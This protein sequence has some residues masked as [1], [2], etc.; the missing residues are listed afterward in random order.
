M[1]T[2][3]TITQFFEN[4]LM[5]PPTVAELAVREA[6]I[7]NGS[8]T[9]E[10]ICLAIVNSQESQTYVHQMFRV[11]QTAFDRLPDFN[12]LDGWVDDLRD[13]SATSMDMINGFLNS[14]EWG[15]TYGSTDVLPATIQSFYQNMLGRAAS[16]QEVSDWLSSGDSLGEIL[17]GVANSAEAINLSNG[18]IISVLQRACETEDP[19]TLYTGL[20]SLFD[21]LPDPVDPTGP[22]TG[23]PGGPGDPVNGPPSVELDN[24]VT[25]LAENSDTSSRI[26]VADIVV[27]DDGLGV[28][29]LALSGDDAGLFEIDGDELFLRANTA[30]DFEGANT[31]LDVTVEVDDTTVGGTPDDTVDLTIQVTDVNEA[32]DI[33]GAETITV[34]HQENDAG[35]VVDVQS[36]DPDLG[37]SEGAGLTYELSQLNGGGG[38]NGWFTID[39]DTGELT[40]K[41]P[42]NF[43][44]PQDG[45]DAGDG[46]G[47]EV[48]EGGGPGGNEGGGPG[49]GE[50]DG[51]NNGR[52]FFRRNVEQI[53]ANPAGDNS[54]QVQVSVTDGE[55]TDTQ[56]INVEVTD[57][58]ERPEI[59][60]GDAVTINFPETL[61]PQ[62]GVPIFVRNVETDDDDDG[63]GDGLTY[64]L[65]NNSG[66]AI[67]NHLFTINMDNGEI[68]FLE[69]PDFEDPKDGTGPMPMPMM[70]RNEGRDPGEMPGGGGNDPVGDNAYEIEVSVTDGEFSDTQRLTINVTNLPDGENLAPV[71]NGGD[72][73]QVAVNEGSNLDYD[74]DSTDDNDSEGN[75]LTYS[76]STNNNR[77]NDNNLFQLSANGVLNF[78]VNPNVDAETQYF[79]QV[80]VTDSGGLTDFQ[81]IIV[82]VT[83]GGQ[84]GRPNLLAAAGAAD[85]DVADLTRSELTPVVSA[86]LARWEDA[87]LSEGQLE[88]LSGLN[89]V[90]MDL[91]EDLLGMADSSTVII[92]S[93]AAGHGWF[94]DQTPGND[95]EFSAGAAPEGLDLLTAVMH[96]MGHSLGLADQTSDPSDLMYAWLDTGERRLPDEANVALT[97]Q[98]VNFAEI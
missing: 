91:H 54:Y 50:D 15:V 24:D 94:V 64:S 4:V 74:V 12:G 25:A 63:E 56:N 76:F 66:E 16:D 82:T 93:N 55:F 37:D 61:D 95:V 53:E 22:D 10:E 47:G 20:S 92:D 45:S 1:T 83:D 62:M 59:I 77:G 26:K 85:N 43:E 69:A 27:S 51:M 19:A 90:V 17:L 9:L 21:P 44:N 6:L 41:V 81:D 88:I 7:A 48:E 71:I 36:T 97:G 30:L 98:Q 13:G 46:D 8:S 14:F 2:A 70:R 39:E 89:I 40:F 11:Y 78:N 5:R 34:Q 35:V 96:E 3:A 23:N 60:G 58:N 32:P 72:N 49:G 87:G 80:T 38:D 42:P 75:G 33:T 29:G 31:A 67:D 28:N 18:P 57:I 65:T 84:N 86:A 73:A 79:V 52:E 68:S